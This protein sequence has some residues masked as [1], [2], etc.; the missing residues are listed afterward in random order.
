MRQ[1]PRPFRH[2]KLHFLCLFTKG[3]RFIITFLRRELLC[4]VSNRSGPIVITFADSLAAIFQF[5]G[6]KLIAVGSKGLEN[7]TRTQIRINSFFKASL[8]LMNIERVQ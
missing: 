1:K 5:F 3:N 4:F 8:V 7:I 6:K 2:K